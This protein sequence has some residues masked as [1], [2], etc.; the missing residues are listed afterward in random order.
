MNEKIAVIGGR[1]AGKTKVT[2]ENLTVA[3]NQERDK[4]KK[5]VQ[6]YNGLVTDHNQTVDKLMGVIHF[7]QLQCGVLYTAITD[8]PLVEDPM[9]KI[10]GESLLSDGKA[11]L[12]Y[13][14]NGFLTFL[15][16]LDATQDVTKAQEAYEKY[17]S[18]GGK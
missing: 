10:P 18:N 8:N 14:R 17:I 11:D 3:L 13:L 12:A 5:L 1:N 9:A 4:Y 15:N 2:I 16:T 6:Q 7:M